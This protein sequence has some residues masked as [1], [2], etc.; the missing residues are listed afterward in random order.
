MKK[1]AQMRRKFGR[2]GYEG[3]IWGLVCKKNV[4]KP[5]RGPT[6]VN[7]FQFHPTSAWVIGHT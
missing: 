1:K 6:A 4:T 3:F 7:N 2:V 5:F